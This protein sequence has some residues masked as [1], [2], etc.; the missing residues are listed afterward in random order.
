MDWGVFLASRCAKTASELPAAHSA[1]SS[2]PASSAAPTA[3]IALTLASRAA[4]VSGPAAV[5][6]EP[7]AEPAAAEPAAAEPAALLVAAAPPPLVDVRGFFF[8]EAGGVVPASGSVPGEFTSTLTQHKC[9][10]RE[11]EAF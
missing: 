11:K 2:S 1:L 6:A 7:A 3:A 10:K 4:E 5:A 8:A 9:G